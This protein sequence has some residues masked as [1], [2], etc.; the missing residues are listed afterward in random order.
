MFNVA[1]VVAV[2]LMVGG[3]AALTN[4][5]AVLGGARSLWAL[6]AAVGGQ[7]L[8]TAAPMVLT[9]IAAAGLL[10]SALGMWWWADRRIVAVGSGSRFRVH[11]STWN[12]EL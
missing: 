7:A 5:D 6:L 2:L 1:I 11:G 8:Q 4:V 9:Y 3:I 10:M 12:V